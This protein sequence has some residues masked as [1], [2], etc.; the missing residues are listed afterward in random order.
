MKVPDGHPE[1]A[2]AAGHVELHDANKIRPGPRIGFAG[3]CGKDVR[4]FFVS[5]TAPENLL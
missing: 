3:T 1:V 5:A 4:S 2:S